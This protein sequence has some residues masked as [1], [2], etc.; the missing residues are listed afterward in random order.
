LIRVV[1][2]LILP[3]LLAVVSMASAQP[4][5]AAD[6]PKVAEARQLYLRGLELVRQA[7]WGEALASFEQSR[8]LRPHPLTAYN[9]GACERALGRY[10][11][12]RARLDEALAEN[13][14][15]GELP[16]SILD[17]ARG[18]LAE[19][20]RLL[21]R[22]TLEVVP[23]GSGIAVDGRPLAPE[24]P[25]SAGQVA[26]V[27]P[28]GPG[29]PAPK[30]PFVVVM[31]PGAHVFTLS[32]KGY[33]DTLINKTYR[34]GYRGNLRIELERLP[35]TIHVLSDEPDGLVTI[36]GKDFG[37]APVDILRPPGN[38]V[39]EVNKPGFVP[40]R[41]EVRVNAG[42]EVTLRARL[43]REQT[44]ITKRWWFWTA[45][46]VVVSGVAVGTYF[47]TR[48]EPEPERPPLDGGSLDWIAP[49]R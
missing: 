5:T 26:N 49:A 45:A 10:T 33:G 34:P 48:T 2:F 44:P 3:A 32:R 17:E 47:A 9:V 25:P 40:Y 18:F 23:A 12:A 36:G 39:V 14:D 20:D 31:D 13:R 42:E 30:G 27:A 19:I 6:D 8:R 11:R 43:A 21:V 4:S 35:A 29:R 41:S 1:A 46:A 24:P 7:Q 38:Y 28:P 22:L 16:P 37:P 15:S